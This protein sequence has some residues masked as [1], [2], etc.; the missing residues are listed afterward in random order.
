MDGEGSFVIAMGE[1]RGE[2][3][4]MSCSSTRKL[5]LVTTKSYNANSKISGGNILTNSS[6]HLRHRVRAESRQVTTTRHHLIT[7]FAV[8]KGM[9]RPDGRAKE[10]FNNDCAGPQ[11]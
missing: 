10:T 5:E 4:G 7:S 8:M 9:Q 2:F 3:R 1:G 11:L 6:P